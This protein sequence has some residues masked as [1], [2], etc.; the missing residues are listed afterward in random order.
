MENEPT[1]QSTA[2]AAWQVKQV[3]AMSV[4]CLVVG[5]AIGY[6]FRGSQ[7]PAP[8]AQP[9]ANAQPAAS[10]GGMGGRMPSLDE[11]KQIAD[12]NAAPL[13]EK[14]KG[15]PNNSDLLFQVGNIIQSH[16]PGLARI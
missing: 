8:P 11:M 9:A 7:S 3:Y 13:L 14:L 15:D 4:I 10:A 6:L 16:F 5:L 2:A 1:T 12:K